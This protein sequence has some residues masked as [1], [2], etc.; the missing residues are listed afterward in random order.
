MLSETYAVGET[1]GR[2]CDSVTPDLIPYVGTVHV[3]RDM[4]YVRQ[5]LGQDKLSYLY[6]AFIR[7]RNGTGTDSINRGYSYGTVI[8]A[9]YAALFPVRMLTCPHFPRLTI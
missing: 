3:A 1:L 4:D 7:G 6:V 8:G 2:D 9:T 5:A